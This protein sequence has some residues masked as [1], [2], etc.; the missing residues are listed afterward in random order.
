MLVGVMLAGKNTKEMDFLANYTLNIIFNY[1][2]C[3][4]ATCAALHA[5]I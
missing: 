2:T 5:R 3:G 1:S 4:F